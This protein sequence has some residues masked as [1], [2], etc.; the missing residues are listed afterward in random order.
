MVIFIHYVAVVLVKLSCSD[1]QWW[2]P[3]VGMYIFPGNIAPCCDCSAA[4]FPSNSTAGWLLF[5]E[6][7]YWLIRDG[8]TSQARRITPT[9]VRIQERSLLRCRSPSHR[10]REPSSTCH[11]GQSRS[12][13]P[14]HFPRPRSLAEAE[15]FDRTSR[16]RTQRPSSPPVASK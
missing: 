15:C 1:R 5:P 11:P 13:Q 14:P 2:L 8:K 4:H 12:V 16:K 6:S 9:S 10:I 3:V 7:P